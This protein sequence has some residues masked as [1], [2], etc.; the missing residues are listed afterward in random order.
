MRPSR[1]SL[2]SAALVARAFLRIGYV[3]A[4]A[5]PLNVVL[6][7][8]QPLTNVFLYFLMAKLIDDNQSFVG[9]D[10]FTYAMVGVVVLRLLGAGLDEFGL[11]VQRTI[12]QGQLEM[13]VTQP[14]SA[15]VLPFVWFEWPLVSRILGAGAMVGVAV[16]L[17]ADFEVDRLLL[18]VLVLALG[19][20]ASHAVGVMASSVRIL[21]KRADPILLLY[22]AAAAIL[23]G[24][25]VPVQLLPGPLQ[26]LS[27]AI[28][29]TYVADAL[30]QLLIDAPDTG[31]RATVGEALIAL[32]AFNV[33]AYAVGLT[34]F[35]RSLRFAQ[36]HGLLGN[37]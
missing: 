1:S 23:S 3:D 21:A 2:R 30:R 13:Y 11:F 10:Y 22:T 20:G 6:T 19:V 25:F 12:D 32:V 17:G 37:Y 16:L 14:V 34:M 4:M 5:Y 18:V 15:T 29:H 27:W 8:V 28:P 7:I 33:I 9:G 36:Q 24:L 26:A 35:R 31:A